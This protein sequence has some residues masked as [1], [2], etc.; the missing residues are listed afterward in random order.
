MT[1]FPSRRPEPPRTHPALV[2]AYLA[3]LAWAV[4]VWI[5]SGG[6]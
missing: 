2:A 1:K 3:I 4:L 6:P 5:R